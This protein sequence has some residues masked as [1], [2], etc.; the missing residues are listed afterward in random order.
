MMHKLL[1]D[2][3]S[4][5]RP[6]H[7]AAIFDNRARLVGPNSTRNTR[8]SARLRRKISSR[9]FPLIRDAVRA[10]NVDAVELAGYE[11]DDLIAAYAREAAR[12]GGRVTIVS[13]DKDLMQLVVDGTIEL[14]DGM[15]AKRIASAEVLEKFGVAPHKVIDVQALAGDSVDNVP[16]VPGIGVKTAAELIGQ[17]GDLETLLARASEI[18]QPKRR[19]NL[20]AHAD[21]ARL[22]KRLVALDEAAPV[23]VP[24]D[25]LR[26]RRSR[27]RPSSPSCAPWSSRR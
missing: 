17:Y 26:C 23:P 12:R 10:F 1:K 11:A 2:M 22:S 5:E 27:P 6:T 20:I 15:K 24:L 14:Y 16:G 21:A 25:H 7:I 8:R 9:S 18:K 4:G 3:K 13:S 19:E